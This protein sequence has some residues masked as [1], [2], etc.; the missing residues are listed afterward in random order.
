MAFTG[1]FSRDWAWLPEGLLHSILEKLVA[2]P[3]YVRFSVVCK[4]WLSVAVLRRRLNTTIHNQIP[5]LILP[6]RNTGSSDQRNSLYSVTDKREYNF[7]IAISDKKRI[8]GSSHG[9][10]FAV[11]E[12]KDLVLI[13]PFTRGTIRLPPIVPLPKIGFEKVDFRTLVEYKVVKASLTA[14]PIL[15]PNDYAVVA[16]YGSSRKLAYIKS[17]DKSWRFLNIRHQFFYDF[18]SYRG[19]IYVVDRSSMVVS[20]DIS[21]SNLSSSSS[22]VKVVVPRK[23]DRPKATYIVESSA[24]DLMLIHRYIV[25]SGYGE[26]RT[27]TFRIFKL[28]FSSS[29]EAERVELESLGGDTLFLS[30]NHSMAVFASNFPGCRPNSIYFLDPSFMIG[31]YAAFMSNDLWIFSFDDYSLKRL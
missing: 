7:K 2:L 11:E 1:E 31:Q 3:D 24:G 10:L 27:S 5:L 28:Q 14:D 8:A 9:W 20:I 17:G 25:R 19:L 16:I 26:K 15:F 21:D 6:P 4:S 18:L 22:V 12:H 13:N 29:G 23:S 30:D